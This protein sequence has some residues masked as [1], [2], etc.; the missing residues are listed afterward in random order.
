MQ[1]EIAWARRIYLSN[2]AAI[3]GPA[4]KSITNY[5]EGPMLTNCPS[6]GKYTIEQPCYECLKKER[7]ELKALLDTDLLSELKRYK[8]LYEA[9]L[10]AC[11]ACRE[12]CL[13]RPRQAKE[14]AT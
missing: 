5:K 14:T 11:P 1:Q 4:Q 13:I 3:Q 6:C 7:D 9:A 2:R 10:K 12:N 8:T